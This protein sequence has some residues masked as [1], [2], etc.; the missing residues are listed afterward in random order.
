VPGQER[1]APDSSSNVRTAAAQPA[2]SGNLFGNLFSF[3]SDEDTGKK[4]SEAKKD[5]GTLDRMVRLIGLRGS[6]PV[7]AETAPAPKSKPTARPAQA[8]AAAPGAI[9]PKPAVVESAKAAEPPR[10]VM[11]ASPAAAPA[12]ALPANNLSGAAPVVPAGTFDS[13]WSAFR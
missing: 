12:P 10:P 1:H 6:E 3:K 11:V 9:R 13:R 7:A 4:K 8:T 2:Q 5:E